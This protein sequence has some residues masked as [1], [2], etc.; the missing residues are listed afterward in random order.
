MDNDTTEGLPTSLL[1]H[2]KFWCEYHIYHGNPDGNTAYEM[3]T[4]IQK[5]TNCKKVGFKIYII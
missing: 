4:C 1:K 3:V 2:L 5:V